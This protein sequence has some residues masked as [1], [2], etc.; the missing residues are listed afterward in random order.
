MTS[1]LLSPIFTSKQ[2]EE[3]KG[4]GNKLITIALFVITIRE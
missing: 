2:K 4:D 1:L 3:E